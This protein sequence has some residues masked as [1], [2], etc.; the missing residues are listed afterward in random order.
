MTIG[1]RL[2][3]L[4]TAGLIQLVSTKPDLE[5]IFR[6][7]L[8]QDA[9]YDSLLKSDRR[10]LHLAVGEILERLYPERREE[11]AVQLADHFSEAGESGRAAAYFILAGNRAARG[12]ANREAISLYT[13]ALTHVSVD[14]PERIRVLRARAGILE[15][16]GEFKKAN[17]DLEKALKE[18]R[19]AGLTQEEWQ[20]LLDLGSLWAAQDYGKTGTYYKEAL[21]LAPRVNTRESLAHSLNRMG[22]WYVNAEQSDEGVNSHLQALAIFKEQSNLDGI[23]ETLDFLGMAYALRG[24]L[25]PARE[26]LEEAQD[27]FNQSGNK[28]GFI[29]SITTLSL[30]NANY[31]GETFVSGD[32]TIAMGAATAQRAVTLAH[33][34][35]WRPGEMWALCCLAVNEGSRGDYQVA[36]K[37]AG[38]ALEIG[39][40]IDH[41]QWLAMVYTGLGFLYYDLYSMD[42]SEESVEIGVKLSR[43]LRSQHWIHTSESIL[44]LVYIAQGRTNEARKIL[45][46]T[47]S[48]DSPAQTMGQRLVWAARVELA[49]SLNHPKT[50]LKY[51][52]RMRDCCPQYSPETPILLLDLLEGKALT[53]LAES[54]TDEK[55]VQL[56]AEAE[57]AL[58][59]AHN[60]AEAQG[61]TSKV[62]RIHRATARLYRQMGRDVEAENEDKIATTIIYH[63]AD[64][65]G[66][67]ALK[68]TFIKNNV[69]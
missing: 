12:F 38:R 11:L 65:I 61:S 4:E 8:I 45:D 59:K 21:K 63:L 34:I 49:L 37:A 16:V 14:S 50:A 67:E 29:S 51:I 44:A 66:D 60:I 15:I 6:H 40:E 64:N 42:R 7:A 22:N 62:W 27:M 35:G 10:R 23:S 52:K 31:Q 3:E 13:Q 57:K 30:L 54:S 19:T 5:Y 9:A 43:W 28:R 53:Q 1:G 47:L 18:A 36:L 24:E 58:R 48:L 69:G 41:K 32:F 20:V 33:E 46:A 55:R 25:K 2:T 56:Q 68:D 39:Q 17:N 26:K